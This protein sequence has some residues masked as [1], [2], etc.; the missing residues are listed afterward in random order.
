MKLLGII[1]KIIVASSGQ[2]KVNFRT[3]QLFRWS[4]LQI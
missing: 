3:P 1:G 2:S 4:I